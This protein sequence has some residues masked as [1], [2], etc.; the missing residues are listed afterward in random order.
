MPNANLCAT[1]NCSDDVTGGS[2][3]RIIG[4]IRTLATTSVRISSQGISA[5]TYYDSVYCGVSVFSS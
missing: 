1:T 4:S 3:S 5:A 2:S